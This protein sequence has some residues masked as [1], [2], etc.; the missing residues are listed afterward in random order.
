MDIKKELDV[1]RAWGCEYGFYI[2]QEEHM[3]YGVYGGLTSTLAKFYGED[4]VK[5]LTEIKVDRN[6]RWFEGIEQAR[7]YLNHLNNGKE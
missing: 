3:L 5:E 7:D 6:Q 1:F 4:L 2:I